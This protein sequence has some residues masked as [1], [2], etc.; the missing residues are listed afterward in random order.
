MGTIRF[1]L[2][3]ESKYTDSKSPIR[4]IYQIKGQRKSIPTGLMVLPFCWDSKEQ[5]AIYIEKKAAKKIAALIPYELFL[6]DKEANEINGKLTGI[7]TDLEGIENFFTANKVIYSV[8]MVAA[9]YMESKQPETK[10][11]ESGTVLYEFIDKYI[12]DHNTI[13]EE[14]SLQVFRSLR[15][16]LR[17]YQ[18]HTRQ[19]VT[20]EKINYSF[21][22]S[23]QSFLVTATG[24]TTNRKGETVP[25]IPISNHTAA[26]QLSTLKTF[27]NYAKKN[28]VQVSDK[29]K[30]FTIKREKMEV[31]A[32]TNEEFE[33]LFYLDLS[34]N[35]KLSQVRDVFCFSCTTGL[36][37]SDLSQ[38]RREHIG[39]DKIDI[40]V[41]KTKDPLTIPLTPYSLAILSRYQ[42]QLKPLPV[43]SNQKMNEYVKQL[44]KMAGIVKP[45]EIVRFQGAKRI[46]NIYPKCELIGTHTGRK[47]FATLSLERGMSAEQVMAIGGWEDYKSFKRYVRVTG[48]LKK[49]VML[50]AWGGGLSDVKLKAIIL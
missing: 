23:F 5:K 12:N 47:T 1:E 43:I 7:K 20:F 4:L 42:Q 29:Y 3:K 48:K 40:T 2:R 26:K 30:D 8:G 34:N 32:L 28:G 6:T 11:D 44:C 27:L 35:K 46:V 37:Y 16:H 45:I 14:G 22:Q 36:R 25:R 21:L 18:K 49:T 15:K 38:L 41:T 13:R 17:D 19:K 9:K 10:K 39:E 31:I 50:K 33:T 24:T